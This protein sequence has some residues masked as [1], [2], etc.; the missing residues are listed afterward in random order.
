CGVQRRVPAGRSISG[1]RESVGGLEVSS[2]PTAGKGR[3]Q[4]MVVRVGV[5][6]EKL[7]AT[8]TVNALHARACRSIAKGVVGDGELVCEWLGEYQRIGRADALRLQAGA[9][10]ASVD[11]ICSHIADILYS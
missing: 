11:S 7:H 5:V 3:L 10:V 1:T 8:V 6:G 2:S 9:G 4:R